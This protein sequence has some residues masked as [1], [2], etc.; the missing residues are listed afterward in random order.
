L[1]KDIGLPLSGSAIK[2]LDQNGNLIEN[3]HGW[4]MQIMTDAFGQYYFGHLL[5]GNYTVF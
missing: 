2:I 4:V 3:K 5:M 1:N